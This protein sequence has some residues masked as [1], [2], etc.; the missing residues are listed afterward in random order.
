V[1]HPLEPAA[2]GRAH[3]RGGGAGA[4][5]RG[6]RWRSFRV[7]GRYAV[8]AWVPLPQARAGAAPAA[9]AAPSPSEP[10]NFCPRVRL[11]PSALWASAADWQC[12]RVCRARRPEPAAPR[13]WFARNSP[14]SLRTSRSH[15]PAPD[16][17]RAPRARPTVTLSPSPG[18]GAR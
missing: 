18:D 14:P 17:L 12:A 2:R 16:S 4:A 10:V 5:G 13:S 11:A 7:P 8:P 1:S 9:P 6:G 15:L 3:R